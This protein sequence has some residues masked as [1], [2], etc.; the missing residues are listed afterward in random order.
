MIEHM[1]SAPASARYEIQD[2]KW[3]KYVENRIDNA[4]H[5]IPESPA[6]YMSVHM[7]NNVI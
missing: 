5:T 3:H 4:H 2:L 7:S 1:P 6:S